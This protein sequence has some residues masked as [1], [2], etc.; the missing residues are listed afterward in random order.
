MFRDR[1]N[2][3]FTQ[4]KLGLRNRQAHIVLVVL[5]VA[6][7]FLGAIVKSFSGLFV[8]EPNAIENF[9][10]HYL[11]FP[12]DLER[13]AKAPWTIITSILIHSDFGHL[14]SNLLIVYFFGQMLE[15]LLGRKQVWQIFI[16]GGVL[17]CLTYMAAIHT[18]PIFETYRYSSYLL[19]ASGG[20]FA[21]MIALVT[22][23]PHYTVNLFAIVPL[24][25]KWIA[26][27]FVVTEL[28]RVS[29][30]NAG[31]H[32]AHFGGMAMGFIFIKLV[33]D[34]FSLP[35]INWSKPKQKKDFKV[36]INKEYKETKSNINQ[37]EVDA[38]LNKIARS[39][40]DSLSKS[41]KEALFKSNKN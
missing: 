4:F 9:Y 24:K 23:A 26:L 39:G 16:L 6:I 11:C 41:E 5:L 13:L 18:F 27:F 33:K 3:F 34:G 35:Q 28:L 31:G 15:N 14:F 38:I 40:Y 37:D 25:V 30:R 36:T 17:G 32:F 29:D 2:Y 1:L 21:L 10:Q 19:G 7:H 8:V 12:S 22:L 20:A